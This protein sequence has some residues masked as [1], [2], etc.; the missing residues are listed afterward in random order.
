MATQIVL[1]AITAGLSGV[2]VLGWKMLEK[3]TKIESLMEKNEKD[4]NEFRED[5][6]ELGTKLDEL[7]ERVAHIE[8]QLESIK[9]GK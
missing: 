6:K 4:H 3:V 5:R 1:Y 2:G 7:T 9:N 8:G